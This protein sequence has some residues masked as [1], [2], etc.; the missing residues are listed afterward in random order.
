VSLSPQLAIV[1]TIFWQDLSV[2]GAPGILMN[3][4][5][6]LQFLHLRS[7][8]VGGKSDA[9]LATKLYIMLRSVEV[10]ALLCVLSILHL[11]ICMESRVV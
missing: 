1:L 6:Y 5:Y 9:I 3:L 8:V 10:V 7:T 11:A 4:P 2:E